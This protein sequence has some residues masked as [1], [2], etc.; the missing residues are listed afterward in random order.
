MIAQ[1]RA[2]KGNVDLLIEIAH[3]GPPGTPGTRRDAHPHKHTILVVS[4]HRAPVRVAQVKKDL[5]PGNP[6]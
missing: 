2:V 3:F 1:V 6:R 4:G 5:I